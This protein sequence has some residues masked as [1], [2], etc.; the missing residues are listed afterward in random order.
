MDGVSIPCSAV[1]SMGKVEKECGY[2]LQCNGYYVL[3]PRYQPIPPPSLNTD[4]VHNCLPPLHPY[5]HVLQGKLITPPAPGMVHVSRQVTHHW[6]MINMRAVTWLTW[7]IEIGGEDFWVLMG[8]QFPC[9]Y[10]RAPEND[11]PLD[12]SGC[13]ALRMCSPKS[14]YLS[15]L[16]PQDTERNRQVGWNHLV[17]WVVH[18]HIVKPVGFSP[19][20]PPGGGFQQAHGL[21][22]QAWRSGCDVRWTK[23]TSAHTV[24]RVVIIRT[25]FLFKYD[26]KKKNKEGGGVMKGRMYLKNTFRGVVV[27]RSGLWKLFN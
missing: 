22:V 14:L 21:S 23:H 20:G 10:L 1:W 5:S 9:F 25:A 4:F 26:L 13:C 12:F 2:G 7:T 17:M 27:Y 6:L 3:L 11:D 16:H 8:K 18:F 24:L 19:V 15:H